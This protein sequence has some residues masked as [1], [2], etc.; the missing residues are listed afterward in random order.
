MEEWDIANGTSYDLLLEENQQKL[1]KQVVEGQFDA[2]LMSPPCGTWSRAPW[3]NTHGPRPL[4]S[5]LEP[6]GFPW[7]EGHRLQKVTDSNSMI[8]LCVQIL[9]LLEK[10]DF[11]TAFLLEHPENLGAV[12]SFK[13]KAR[14]AWFQT[15]SSQVRPASI[16]QLQELQRFVNNSKVFSQVFHQCLFGADQNQ[17][18]FLHACPT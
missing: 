9:Q 14:K 4:R 1:L 17:L 15:I 2:I 6:W 10:K 8:W 12:S 5:H 7:L 11:V 13:R 3:A 18:G 16:W